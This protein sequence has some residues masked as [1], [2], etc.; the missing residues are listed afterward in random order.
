[1]F[2]IN[3]AVHIL[4]VV[5]FVT[6][7]ITYKSFVF[8]CNFSRVKLFHV[9]SYLSRVECFEITLFTLNVLMNWLYMVLDLS[10]TACLV[11]A[12]VTNNFITI[13]SIQQLV[14]YVLA[15]TNGAF[16]WTV[17]YEGL[18]CVYLQLGISDVTLGILDTTILCTPF[19]CFLKLL[20]CCT[21]QPNSCIVHH[22]V[23]DRCVAPPPYMNMGKAEM[24]LFK[25][26]Q[27]STQFIK[28]QVR[29]TSPLHEYERNWCAPSPCIFKFLHI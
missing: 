19:M 22:P 24:C 25:F 6:T 17:S 12:F 26:L 21:F 10:I 11:I 27:I 15:Y 2:Q 3:M 23:R 14:M 29:C 13:Y 16:R 7:L 9:L 28:R 20:Q 5:F 8:L 4:F 1:M 18:Y